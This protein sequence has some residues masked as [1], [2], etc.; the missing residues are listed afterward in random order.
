[1]AVTQSWGYEAPSSVVSYSYIDYPAGTKWNMTDNG[2]GYTSYSNAACPPDQAE[3]ITF[4]TAK[5]SNVYKE[6]N[7]NAL[8]VPALKSG[9]KCSINV[10]RVLRF[11]STD[12]T[13]GFPV[14]VDV[15][16]W[17]TLSFGTSDYALVS[18]ENRKALLDFMISFLELSKS[19]DAVWDQLVHGHTM[20]L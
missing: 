14:D 1:M 20:C 15:P 2:A 3:T 12:S 16:F 5:V 4:R 9:R 19:E 13:T 17:G 10:H 8:N 6:N 18:E 7:I 11:S